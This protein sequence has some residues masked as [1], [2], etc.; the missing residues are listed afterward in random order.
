[1]RFWQ[2]E[3]VFDPLN[4]SPECHILLVS[5]PNEDIERFLD[6]PHASLQRFQVFLDW[7]DLF[8]DDISQLCKLFVSKHTKKIAEYNTTGKG[9]LSGIRSIPPAARSASPD[10]LFHYSSDA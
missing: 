6:L 3:T 4:T 7:I 1:M 8:A 5:P 2:A 10:L 9:E